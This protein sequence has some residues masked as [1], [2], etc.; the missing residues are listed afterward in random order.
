VPVMARHRILVA[1]DGSEPAFQALRQA[2]DDAM[3]SDAGICVVT[4][5]PELGRVGLG[6]AP[7]QARRYLVDR[8]FRPE[9]HAP[10]GD[11]ATEIVR[12]AR[13]C[14]CDIILLGTRDGP[15]GRSIDRCESGQV[16]VRCPGGVAVEEGPRGDGVY[17]SV[18]DHHRSRPPSRSSRDRDDRRAADGRPRGAGERSIGHGPTHRQPAR[19]RPGAT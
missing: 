16:V 9:I 19:Q 2:A 8:G 12:I 6:K 1:Y 15:I 14:G 5:G 11:P 10:V 4:V 17:S 13:E 18:S 3:R 7:G